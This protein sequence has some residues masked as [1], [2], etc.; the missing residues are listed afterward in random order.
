VYANDCISPYNLYVAGINPLSGPYFQKIGGGSYYLTNNSP[1]QNTGTTNIDPALL[2]DLAAKTTYPPIAYTNVTFSTATTLSPQAQRDNDG[3]PDLG[4]HYDPLDYTFGGCKASSNLTFTAGTAAGWFRT[5]SGWI[6]AGQA[7]QM[8]GNITVAFNGTVAAPIYWVR[9]N[10]VQ[11][12]D[13]TAGYG[14]GSIESWASPPI[15]LVSGN[16]LH[17]TAMAGEPFNGYFADDYGDLHAEMVNSEFWSGNLGNYGDSM[18]YTN[19]LMWRVGL[20]LFNGTSGNSLVLRNCTLIGGAF[21]IQRIS[22]GNNTVSVRDCVFDGTS[23]ET[24][25]YYGG[26]AS[27]TDYD[28]NAYTN[29]S[30]P[31]SIGGSHDV[32]VSGGFNWQT[33]WFGNFYLPSGSSL[34]D[35]GSTT[36][37][38][39][40][41]YHFT[42]QT[43]QVPETNSQVDIGYHYVA[44]DAYG[45]PLD[46]NG[47]GIPDYLED[48]NG[49]GIWDA[50]DLGEWQ[51]SPYGLNG[52]NALQVFTPLK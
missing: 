28:Y 1:C 25:D 38:V 21:E 33:S 32:P 8:S 18:S 42:A 47:D 9:L 48:A 44:T 50:G 36:A 6:Y 30:D 11:E 34:I 49:N 10:T 7:I 43:N 45:N 23:I 52:G 19:C 20:G 31:F 37:N 3:Q 4:Y 12:N 40:G 24:S 2:A 51:I 5:T 46:S 14:H 41:L 17:C 16:F 29:S 35:T 15:P 13:Q 22:G 39:V 26:N 27:Y